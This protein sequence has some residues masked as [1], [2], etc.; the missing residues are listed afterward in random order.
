M[1][2]RAAG[3]KNKGAITMKDAC[4]FSETSLFSEKGSSPSWLASYN[5]HHTY[6]SGLD[7]SLN[8]SAKACLMDWDESSRHMCGYS[9]LQRGVIDCK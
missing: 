8:C 2:A 9:S 5:L 1:A 4:L 3:Q 7:C 6:A